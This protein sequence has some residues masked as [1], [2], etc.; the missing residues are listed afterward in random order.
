MTLL[1]DVTSIVEVKKYLLELS[2]L[3]GRRL[4]NQKKYAKVVCVVIKDSFFKL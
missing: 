4:R 1:H 3:V 2:E